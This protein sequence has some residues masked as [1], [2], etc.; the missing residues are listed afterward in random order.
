MQIL[1]VQIG[2]HIFYAAAL[3]FTILLIYLVVFLVYGCNLILIQRI[4]HVLVFRFER[5]IGS[6]RNNFSFLGFQ[7]SLYLGKLDAKS[8]EGSITVLFLK[9]SRDSS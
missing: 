8:L 7:I 6:C 3:L 5:F 1:F 2:I 9:P 4:D